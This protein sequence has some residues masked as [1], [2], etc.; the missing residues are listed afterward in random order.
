MPDRGEKSLARAKKI[1]KG[2]T[3]TESTNK[4]QNVCWKFALWQHALVTFQTLFKEYSTA[5][6]NAKVWG[7][8]ITKKVIFTIFRFHGSATLSNNSHLGSIPWINRQLKQS[9][10]EGLSRIPISRNYIRLYYLRQCF[11]VLFKIFFFYWSEFFVAWYTL[12]AGRADLPFNLL[13]LYWVQAK[14]QFQERI[15]DR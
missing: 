8:I 7:V 14:T 12:F 2:Y 10:I 4:Y 9:C 5:T 15:A 3:E 11:R 6:N 1:V 13:S